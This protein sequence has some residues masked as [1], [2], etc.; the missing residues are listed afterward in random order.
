MECLNP[1]PRNEHGKLLY[2]IQLRTL[3]EKKRHVQSFT[4]VATKSFGSG[5][6]LVS[7][8]SKTKHTRSKD[9]CTSLG[10][11]GSCH[12]SEMMGDI[13]EQEV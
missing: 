11:D 3:E 1:V 6:S 8:T 9:A 2:D 5:S 12:S 10:D 4:G 13:E 7:K